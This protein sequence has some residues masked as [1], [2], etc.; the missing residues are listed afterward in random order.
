MSKKILIV[1]DNENNMILI[2]DILAYYHYESIEAVN[3]KE[4]VRLAREQKPDLILMDIQMPEMSGY[5][6]AKTLKSDPATSHIK[7]I[8]ITSYATKG[9]RE[10]VLE[11]GF[12]C[13]ISKPINTRELPKIVKE[14]LGE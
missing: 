4:G 11:S 10:K 6:A 8:G 12:D 14:M 9:D 1:E 13:Y 2:R 3:G 7:I 5:D